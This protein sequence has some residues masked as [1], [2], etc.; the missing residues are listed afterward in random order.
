MVHTLE[1]DEDG[2]YVPCSVKKTLYAAKCWDTWKHIKYNGQQKA[3]SVVLKFWN[4]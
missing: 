3:V 2:D 4:C 1:Q